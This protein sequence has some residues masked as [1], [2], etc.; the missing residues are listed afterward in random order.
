KDIEQRKQPGPPHL[1]GSFLPT[2]SYLWPCRVY[3]HRLPPSGPDER[4]L[5]SPKFP[6]PARADR[7]NLIRLVR[8]RGTGSGA[9]AFS[10]RSGKGKSVLSLLESGVQADRIKGTR[11][12]ENVRG[13]L[14]VSGSWRI[15]AELDAANVAQL[16]IKLGLVTDAQVQEGWEEVGQ[17][18]GEADP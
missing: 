17:R 18:G 2:A 13:S 15:M 9:I 1:P 3:D 14:L 6:L 16:A 8:R 11:V 5:H 4:E 7:Q 12:W 10:A